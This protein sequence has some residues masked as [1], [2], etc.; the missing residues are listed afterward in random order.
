MAEPINIDSPLNAY[1]LFIL[2]INAFFSMEIF[3]S[4]CVSVVCV[5][6]PNPAILRF[7]FMKL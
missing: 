6:G 4:D 2:S 1:E 7:D 5:I 3:L